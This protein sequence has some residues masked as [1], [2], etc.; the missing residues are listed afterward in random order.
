MSYTVYNICFFQCCQEY[1]LFWVKMSH[2]IP[3]LEVRKED[4]GA[5]VHT[6]S[7]TDIF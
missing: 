6:K 3:A 5:N 7:Y 2:W 1:I 4:D